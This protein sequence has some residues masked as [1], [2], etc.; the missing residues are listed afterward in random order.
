M[1]FD[2][3]GTLTEQGMQLFGFRVCMGDS[4]DQG[5]APE[6]DMFT[7]NI[8][9]RYINKLQPFSSPEKYEKTAS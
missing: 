6:F 1:V 3:T 8:N 2:K 9:N 4:K 7:D 5:Y